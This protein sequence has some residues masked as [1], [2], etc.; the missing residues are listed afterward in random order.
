MSSDSEMLLKQYDLK[1]L[2]VASQVPKG[3]DAVV[4]VDVQMSPRVGLPS[5]IPMKTLENGLEVIDTDKIEV[6]CRDHHVRPKKNEKKTKPI[7]PGDYY[8][9]AII[10]DQTYKST[11]SLLINEFK[12]TKFVKEVIPQSEALC[13]LGHQAIRIDVPGFKMKGPYED[14]ALQIFGGGKLNHQVIYDINNKK[15][16]NKEGEALSVMFKEKSRVQL[17]GLAT[18]CHAGIID[19]KLDDAII[20][21]SVAD[22]MQSLESCGDISI[23]SAVYKINGNEQNELVFSVRSQKPTSKLNATHIA[24]LFGGGGDPRRSAAQMKLGILRYSTSLEEFTKLIQNEVEMRLR[25]SPYF[26]SEEDEKPIATPFEESKSLKEVIESL[27][28]TERHFTIFGKMANVKKRG[29]EKY[30]TLGINIDSES[31][32]GNSVISENDIT[33]LNQINDTMTETWGQKGFTD[34]EGN[35]I[36]AL[37]NQGVKPYFMGVYCTKKDGKKTKTAEKKKDELV[38]HL[39]G[40]TIKEE[41]ILEREINGHKYEVTVVKSPIIDL[42]YASANPALIKCLDYEMKQRIERVL[43]GEE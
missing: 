41:E 15:I 11:T 33:S 29:N 12:D 31:Y 16:R 4:L 25:A 26:P 39:F 36:Y 27:E 30:L 8:K 7:I 14:E 34:I 22:K 1:Y 43:G 5:S 42:Q 28:T 19:A 2:D 40:P 24:Q 3:V 18:Y 20:V 21:A 38:Q 37:V 23:A 17:P 10:D 6:H 9:T 32:N 13:T 35:V